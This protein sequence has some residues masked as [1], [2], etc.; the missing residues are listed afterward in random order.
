MGLF[1]LSSLMLDEF[2]SLSAALSAVLL[3]RLVI[4]EITL[5]TCN[6]THTHE[7][8]LKYYRESDM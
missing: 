4:P 8:I 6:P 7:I 3:S 5:V 1:F 2:C